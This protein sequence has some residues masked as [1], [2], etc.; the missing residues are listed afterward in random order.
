[1]VVEGKPRGASKAAEG[2][3]KRDGETISTSSES[4]AHVNR[5]ARVEIRANVVSPHGKEKTPTDKDEVMEKSGREAEA[6]MTVSLEDEA[7]NVKETETTPSKKKTD[8][9]EVDVAETDN[10]EDSNMMTT[11]VKMNKGHYD[12]K[13]KC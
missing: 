2:A 3:N 1:V 11:N 8:R 10:E 12:C 7:G 13:S 4:R 5:K 9:M 6:G